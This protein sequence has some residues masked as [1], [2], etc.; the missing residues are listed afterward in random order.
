MKR[1]D[2][3]KMKDDEIALSFSKSFIR[4]KIPMK[5]GDGKEYQLYI[6]EMPD[7]END[8]QDI[9]RTFT[10]E[11]SRL[12]TDRKYDYIKYTYLKKDRHY[13]VMRSRYDENSKTVIVKETS[14]M[15]GQEIADV[16]ARYR[17]RKRK[18]FEDQLKPEQ[19]RKEE[20]Q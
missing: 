3:Q 13:R 18:E 17:S 20:K 5:A 9:K 8:Q 14:E 1:K 10:V 4:T 11:E 2:E 7:E 16:F 15:T 6:I 12:G 19:E